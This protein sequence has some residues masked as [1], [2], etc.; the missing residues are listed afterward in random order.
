M[1]ATVTASFDSE[2]LSVLNEMV[3]AVAT[4]TFEFQR[5]RAYPLLGPRECTKAAGTKPP[6]VLQQ[7]T[8]QLFPD[9]LALHGGHTTMVLV[10]P[11][12]F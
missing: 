3:V 10:Q 12:A 7:C 11:Q 6:D 5:L 9:S 1:R 2:R 8:H 4:E